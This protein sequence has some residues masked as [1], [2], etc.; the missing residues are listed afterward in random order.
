VYDPILEARCEEMAR[1][2]RKK[3]RKR[4][5][6]VVSLPDDPRISRKRRGTVSIAARAPMRGDRIG[7]SEDAV[8]LN[9]GRMIEDAP[10]KI[11]GKP[12]A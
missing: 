12:L 1:A 9:V 4:K 3:S 6:T 8:W 7:E 11:S 2:G 10:G 5:M